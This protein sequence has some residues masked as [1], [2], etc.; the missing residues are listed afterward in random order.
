MTS[1]SHSVHRSQR[2][3]VP[4]RYCSVLAISP[5]LSSC[6]IDARGYILAPYRLSPTQSGDVDA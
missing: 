1:I 2:A 5:S 3:G 4:H 6:E